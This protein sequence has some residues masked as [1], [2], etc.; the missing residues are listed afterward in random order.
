MNK[1]NLFIGLVLIVG[2]VVFASANFVPSYSS[3]DDT[4][5]FK[6]E[7]SGWYLL[8]SNVDSRCEGSIKAVWIWLPSKQMYVGS[9][10]GPL[11]SDDGALLSSEVSLG[12]IK[13]G[14]NSVWVYLSQ[15][16]TFSYKFPSSGQ[17][18]IKLAGGWNFLVS[19]PSYIGKS[20]N[21]V[22]GNCNIDKA[23][24]WNADVRGGNGWSEI[25]DTNNRFDSENTGIGFIVKVS[26]GCTFG[27]ESNPVNFPA[28]PN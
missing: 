14:L 28:I 7:K 10:S 22:K 17:D 8:P 26:E 11:S 2:M 20:L 13:E 23:Y 6:F 21:D 3:V 12:Y 1:W 25:G 5:I 15:P 24:Y 16:C 18:S 4:T 27:S 19:N 9:V